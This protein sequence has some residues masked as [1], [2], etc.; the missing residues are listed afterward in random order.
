MDKSRI[1]TFGNDFFSFFFNPNSVFE[2]ISFFLPFYWEPHK[3]PGNEL[4]LF[5]IA[6]S[7]KENN[8]K[9]ILM[10]LRQNVMT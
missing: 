3:I 1:I 9:I 4:I 2:I 8:G 5:N 10:S 7:K 6:K